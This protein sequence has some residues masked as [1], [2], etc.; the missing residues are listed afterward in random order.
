MYLLQTDT[1]AAD[2]TPAVGLSS[3]PQNRLRFANGAGV[4]IALAKVS[5]PGI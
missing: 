5:P 2:A 1:T 4:M 3:L